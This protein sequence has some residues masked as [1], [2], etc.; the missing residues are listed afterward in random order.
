M[1]NEY[2]GKHHNQ[3]VT[4]FERALSTLVNVPHA[5]AVNSGTAAI[6]LALLAM[7]IGKGDVVIAPTF[8]Y[9]ATI[10]P[11]MYVGATPVL[12]RL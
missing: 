7:G 12:S 11:I 5:V 4:D 1:L 9:V 2:A 3:I 8:T 10:N 6:H